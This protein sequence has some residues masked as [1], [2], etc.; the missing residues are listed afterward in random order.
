MQPPSTYQNTA[1]YF[2]RAAD[3]YRAFLKKKHPAHFWKSVAESEQRHITNTSLDMLA[4][5]RSDVHVYGELLIQ[6]RNEKGKLRRVVPDNMIVLAEERPDVTMN[7]AIEVQKS[8]PFFVLEYVTE[9]NKRKHH[10]KSYGKYEAEL[11]VP[12]YTIFQLDDRKLSLLAYDKK[13]GKYQSLPPNQN[14]RYAIRELDLEVGLLDGW[15]RFWWKGALLL[16]TTELHAEVV[17]AR[18]QLE[19]RKRKLTAIEDKDR[20]IAEMQAE[21]ERLRKSAG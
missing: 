4:S 14:G 15:A 11:K 3:E 8:R 12:Y 7:F 19:V 2:D 21:L 6:W 20:L 1:F 9:T 13:Q 18:K 5:K 17:E 10:Q 16:T